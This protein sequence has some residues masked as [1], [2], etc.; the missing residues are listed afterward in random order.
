MGWLS[1]IFPESKKPAK[2]P[3]VSGAKTPEGNPI[4]P[5]RVG[6]NGEYDQNG[7]AKRVVAA[8]DENDQLDDIETLWVAQAGSTVVLKGT[9]PSEDALKQAISIA[10]GVEGTIKVD[11]SQVTTG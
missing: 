11:S 6:L 5:A 10:Q 9:V 4:P 3:K 7:L 2:L 8:F 1:R